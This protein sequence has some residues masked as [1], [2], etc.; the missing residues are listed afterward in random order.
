VIGRGPADETAEPLY[1]SVALRRWSDRDVRFR[2]R[3]SF[4][5][6]DQILIVAPAGGLGKQQALA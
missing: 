5:L 3:M 6:P 4:L 1:V 2:R